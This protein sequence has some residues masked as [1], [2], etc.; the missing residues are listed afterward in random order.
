MI[1]QAFTS[2]LGE[3]AARAMFKDGL[4]L[5]LVRF[6]GVF[7]GFLLSVVLARVLGPEGL[8]LYAF[9]LVVLT[10]CAIP[11]QMGL[12]VLIQRET[13][14]GLETSQWGR[15]KTL[16]HWSA[17]VVVAASVLIL[18]VLAA[19][20]LLFDVFPRG[21]EA[22]IWIGMPLVPVLAFVTVTGAKL[23]G[24]HNVAKGQ[25]GDE[26][27]RPLLLITLIVIAVWGAGHILTPLI[28][29]VL[30]ILACLVALFVSLRMLRRATPP[31]IDIARDGPADAKWRWTIV[32]LALI[33]AF[34]VIAQSTD[35]LMLG[36]FAA[37]VDVG[38]YRVA[39]SGMALGMFGLRLFDML[40]A[41][42]FAVLIE[43]DDRAGVTRLAGVTAGLSLIVAV[44]VF[45]IFLAFGAPLL[46][47]IFGPAFRDSNSALCIL[48]AAQVFA[49]WFGPTTMLLVYARR[50]ALSL[51]VL[52]AATVINIIL[53][54]FLIPVYGIIGAAMATAATI[55]FKSLVLWLVV[56]RVMLV[57][58]SV[59]SAFGRKTQTA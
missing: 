54:I 7:L 27:L 2:I 37:P 26:V 25:L 57:D 6:L 52:G 34:Q 40:F 46:G 58:S 24:L 45:L 53:N 36:I 9:A 11:V 10:I 16:W 5:F 48:L 15:I 42:K 30:N 43:R 18:L 31:E 12:P 13:P 19:F 22:L 17:R 23:R 29:M 47:T 39:L 55:L 35:I 50:E 14:R 51:W 44:P 20:L 28:A 4:W 1:R 8:G 49:A 41:P 59:R 33:S 32:T 21:S 38:L 3:Q 56:R